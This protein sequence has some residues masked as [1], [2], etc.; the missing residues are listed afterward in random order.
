MPL[1]LGVQDGVRVGRIVRFVVSPAP[2]AHQVHDH[3]PLELLTKG[4]RQAHDADRVLGLVS[5]HVEDRCADHLGDV[6]RIERGLEILGPRR[7]ADLVVDD[8]VD[9]A[10]R[11]IAPQS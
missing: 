7:E 8:D 6:G 9:R 11:A 4:Q 10:T 1:D 3:V 2:V 5:V